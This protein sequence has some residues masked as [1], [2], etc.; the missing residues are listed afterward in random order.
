MDGGHDG[1]SFYELDGAMVDVMIDD[2]MSW[3]VGVMVDVCI[4]W[5]VGVMVDVVRVRW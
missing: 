3:M 5:M 4:S 2:C 1:Q